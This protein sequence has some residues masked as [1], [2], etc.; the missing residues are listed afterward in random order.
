MGKKAQLDQ[1]IGEMKQTHTDALYLAARQIVFD[2][3]KIDPSIARRNNLDYTITELE[4]V[5]E[6]ELSNVKT[7]LIAAQSSTAEETQASQLTDTSK[8]D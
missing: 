3:E 6:S 1:L 7:P 4:L 8:T 5:L 2:L